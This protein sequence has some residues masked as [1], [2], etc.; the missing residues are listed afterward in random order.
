[1]MLR[2]ADTGGRMVEGVGFS[3]TQPRRSKNNGVGGPTAA[4]AGNVL[5]GVLQRQARR[6][7]IQ[8]KPTQAHLLTWR[9]LANPGQPAMWWRMLGQDRMLWN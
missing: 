4:L 3:P 6:H 8:L 5:Q 7:S 1:M 9:V 2:A